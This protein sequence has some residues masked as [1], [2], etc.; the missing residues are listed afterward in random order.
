MAPYSDPGLALFYSSTNGL[1]S[2]NT[3]VD[4]ICHALCEVIER[5][6]TA[7]ALARA[8]VRP[9]VAA[10]LADMGF[11]EAARRSAEKRR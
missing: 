2:G 3:R 9:A 4:A 8:E 11:G 5:D 1:A 7:L 10:I 6:A